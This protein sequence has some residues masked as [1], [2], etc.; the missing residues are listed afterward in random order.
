[1]FYPW[2]KH[3]PVDVELC[4]IQLPGRETRLREACFTNL[5]KLVQALLPALL[6]DL[7]RPFAFLGHSMGALIGFELS[8]QLQQRQAP[9]PIHLFVAG[10]EAP[11]SRS[12]A[13]PTHHLPV[14]AF[15][16]EIR[17]R[18]N[19]IPDALL[20]S[21]ELM[22]MLLPIL[23]ADVT[24]VETYDYVHGT[25]LDCSI[26]A[27]GGRQDA[28]VRLADLKAWQHQTRQ[29]FRVH[30]LPGDHFFVN[31]TRQP[32]LRVLAQELRHLLSTLT[33]PSRT[34]STS[35]QSTLQKSLEAYS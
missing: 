13:T 16:Q 9:L 26:T 25:P 7:D 10:R 32:F 29:A 1:M 20:H 12:L 6:P 8:R 19:G 2:R 31:N 21:P 34:R 17:C 35:V 5:H 11:Q 23:R 33:E 27:F 3:L 30:L 15:I 14:T 22:E 4:P 28:Q 18:Y 24:L